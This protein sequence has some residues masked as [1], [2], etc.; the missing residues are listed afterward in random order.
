MPTSLIKPI[1]KNVIRY[2][3]DVAV[4]HDVMRRRRQTME[5]MRRM[6]TPVL[7]KHKFNIDDVSEEKAQISPRFDTVYGQGSHDDP[8]SN[9][10]GFVSVETSRGEW[11]DPATGGIVITD[12]PTQTLLPAPTYRGYGPGYLTYVIL[13]DAPEDIYKTSEEGALIKIQQARVQ[14]PWWP[15]MG[16]NDIMIV[17]E[18]DESENVINSFERYELKQV[19]PISMRGRDRHGRRE[20]EAL[21]AGNRHFVGQY[22]EATKV[23]ETDVIYKVEVDR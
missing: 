12:N 20:V 17:V 22:C 14:L 6:G 11:I 3:G 13:P 5:T 18:L 23:P 19:Q 8:I 2:K 16:D 15:L 4:P 1:Y 9:G 10:V 7:L 21:S